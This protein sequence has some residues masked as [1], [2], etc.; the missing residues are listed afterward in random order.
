MVGMNGLN[1]AIGYALAAYMGL[2]FYYVHDQATQW[3]GPLGIALIW[4]LVMIAICIVIPESPRYLLMT[5]RIAEARDII[6]KLHTIDGDMYQGFARSEF[7]QMAKQAEMDREV[8]I[9][10][11]S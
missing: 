3:R 8:N 4:P 11:V 5:G 7:Y 1:I 2:A 10:W 6:F 9:S